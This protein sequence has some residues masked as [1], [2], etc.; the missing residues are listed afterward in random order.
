M[1]LG[2]TASVLRIHSEEQVLHFFSQK[3]ILP[4]F[5]LGGGSNLLVRDG[6]LKEI[7]LKV[8]IEG[9]EFK[10]T[11]EFLEVK[12][13]GGVSFDFLLQILTEKMI[14]SPQILSG[15]PGTVGA[16]PVQ[17][18]GA[19]GEE[20]ATFIH[21]LRAFDILE[22]K[23]VTLSKADCHFS[24]RSSI[25]NSVAKGRYFISL[26]TFRFPCGPVSLAHREVL[27]SFGKEIA[28]PED[29]KKL[30]EAILEIRTKKCMLAGEKFP[31]SAGSFF[32]NVVV[33]RAVYEHLKESYSDMPGHPD[34][35]GMK[36]PTAWLIGQTSFIKGYVWKQVGV[37]PY[38]NLSLINLGEGTFDQ[39]MELAQMIQQEVYEKFSLHI[40]IE[41]E[42]I[43]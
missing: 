36:I 40:S 30:R 4:F 33:S 15:I 5:I 27:E 26:V 22:K 20:V 32:K 6:D 2:G 34:G 16:A 14:A 17:N 13:G 18:I 19:Y 41:P 9:I 31:K 37:S 1:G 43:G 25:F 10:G 42:I 29:S 23:W 38:H 12:V 8:E 39:L 35:E 7:C 11:D 3:E 21:S 28:L 24:Y